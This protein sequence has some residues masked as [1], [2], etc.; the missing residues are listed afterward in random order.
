MSGLDNILNKIKGL[1]FVHPKAMQGLPG[2]DRAQ[3]STPATGTAPKM[4][5]VPGQQKPG[6]DFKLYLRSVQLFFQDFFGKKLPYFFKNIGPVMKNA[7]V[8]WG[9]L[10]QDEQISYGLLG[11]GSMMFVAGIVLVIVF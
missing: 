5:G 10:P 3:N 8:W 2:K 9:G 7:P 1:I 11:L 6:F 4:K